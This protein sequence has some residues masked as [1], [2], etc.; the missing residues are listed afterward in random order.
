MQFV[1]LERYVGLLEFYYF[2][3]ELRIFVFS[4]HVF[5]TLDLQYTSAIIYIRGPS[6]RKFVDVP[7]IFSFGRYFYFV[8][9]TFI[10]FDSCYSLI[11]RSRPDL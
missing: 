10:F 7:F 9:S 1:L 11:D 4:F 3:S 2:W 5:I 8:S 6:L